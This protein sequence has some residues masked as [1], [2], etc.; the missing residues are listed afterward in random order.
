[1][2]QQGVIHSTD[3]LIE[4]NHDYRQFFADMIAS[5]NFAPLSRAHSQNLKNA[6]VSMDKNITPI[7][8]DNTNLKP[9]EPKAYV[10]HAL[11][12]GYA[13]ENIEFVEVGT[14]GLSAEELAERNTHGVPLDKIKAMIKTYES[15]GPLTLK[16]VVKAKAMYNNKPKL[17]ASVVLDDSSQQ[18]LVTALRHYVP[19]GWVIIAHH[20]TINFDKG[21]GPDRQ[22]D[23]GKVVNLVAS[24]IGISDMV[25][26]VKVHGYPSDNDIPHITLAINKA[27]GA[28]PVMSNNIT[29][30]EKMNSHINLRGIVTEQKLG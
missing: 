9:S 19:E 14:A 6:K 29:K 16:K 8:I 26:A 27:G 12:L 18:K 22:E 20:M 30:W 7:I 5:K 17:F 11:S 10:E 4:A 24:E 2:V 25:V 3:D 15:V 13:D 28:K 23:N 1:L 21:L